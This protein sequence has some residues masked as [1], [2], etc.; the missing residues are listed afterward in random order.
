MTTMNQSP[1]ASIFR[2]RN[3]TTTNDCLPRFLE[4]NNSSLLDESITGDDIISSVP[5]EEGAEDERS[6]NNNREK[7]GP[8]DTSL[9]TFSVSE[10]EN[11][12]HCQR[13]SLK[14][15]EDSSNEGVAVPDFLKPFLGIDF[16][17]FAAPVK[18]E[19]STDTFLKASTSTT[20]LSSSSSDQLEVDR[21]GTFHAVNEEDSAL[22]TDLSHLVTKHPLTT[23][24]KPQILDSAHTTLET[25]EDCTFSENEK[26]SPRSVMDMQPFDDQKEDDKPSVEE[27]ESPTMSSEGSI[28]GDVISSQTSVLK[29]QKEDPTLLASHLEKGNALGRRPMED[30]STACETD[31]SSASNA[32][33][34]HN[35]NGSPHDSPCHGQ[36]KSSESMLPSKEALESDSDSTSRQNYY[37]KQAIGKRITRLQA[38]RRRMAEKKEKE[39]PPSNDLPPPSRLLSH[40]PVELSRPEET[41]S[42]SPLVR[43]LTSLRRQAKAVRLR[44]GNIEE[45]VTSLTRQAEQLEA[46]L[47]QTE[48]RLRDES[49]MLQTTQGEL[50]AIEN[51]C[52]DALKALEAS[53]S[54]T[55]THSNDL[56][57]AKQSENPSQHTSPRPQS[58]FQ[59]LSSLL[60]HKEI[61]AAAA[62]ANFASTIWSAATPKEPLSSHTMQG[63]PS[64]E[65]MVS[66]QATELNSESLGL[67]TCTPPF[68]GKDPSFSARRR[69]RSW[70]DDI[71]D[72]SI[73]GRISPITFNSPGM[74]TSTPASPRD[75][76]STVLFGITADRKCT[77]NRDDVSMKRRQSYSGSVADSLCSRVD[78]SNL[79]SNRPPLQPR[80]SWRVTA[81]M[82]SEFQRGTSL[83]KAQATQISPGPHSETL[84]DDRVVPMRKMPSRAVSEP[85]IA[86]KEDTEHNDTTTSLSRKGVIPYRKSLLAL[87]PVR[88]TYMKMRDL[89]MDLRGWPRSSF[90]LEKAFPRSNLSSG[91]LFLVKDGSDLGIVARQLQRR[92]LELATDEDEERFSP[93]NE[94]IHL[95]SEQ[96]GNFVERL[97]SDKGPSHPPSVAVENSTRVSVWTGCSEGDWPMVKARG[98]IQS[99]A[100]K[101]CEFLL[102]ST[103][104]GMYES[105]GCER[106]D[107]HVYDSWSNGEDKTR[108]AK[109]TKSSV[110]LECSLDRRVESSCLMISDNLYDQDHA[111]LVVS[112]S[113]WQQVKT[114]IK[115]EN[116]K[117]TFIDVQLI[118]P[119][120][121][122]K[123]E[124]T[125]VSQILLPDG[126][127]SD[128]FGPMAPESAV[129]RIRNLQRLFMVG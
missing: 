43:D 114:G 21:K 57:V 60:G 92:G 80:R 41:P 100:S 98:V 99:K 5:S 104:V 93:S 39:N 117:E 120:G 112:R 91:D 31:E 69:T 26:P 59:T 95:L 36:A 4:E 10:E 122:E 67:S 15:K 34:L 66:L 52:V 81:S 124:L 101:L 108:V 103:K 105:S 88:G 73:T 127:S 40:I 126:V 82:N 119:L 22:H 53:V 8:L 54:L 89:H 129:D 68:A 27:E 62:T 49:Y 7:D 23:S 77:R 106:A 32:L 111:F 45:R 85:K 14:K 78:P 74:S 83:R 17:P 90:L 33:L 94:T 115:K 37:L 128:L 18:S 50:D 6:I 25:N 71:R 13:E 125:T 16:M 61:L 9:L 72:E 121:S 35:S 64:T 118:R 48:S 116:V 20:S 110:L 123:C 87:G 84:R 30:A 19:A 38:A 51:K 75:N 58:C 44:A 96:N 97:A 12:D 42:Y 56:R 1:F 63:T 79:K 46:A 86:T 24:D 76:D 2:K 113:I 107:V 55:T 11:V 70:G 29:G 65:Q 102:D 3:N 47:M 109:I 28:T